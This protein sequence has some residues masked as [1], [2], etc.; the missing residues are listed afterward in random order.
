MS[1]IPSL[2]ELMV[3]LD[4]A[5]AT[6]PSI[7]ETGELAAG[8]PRLL[9]DLQDRFQVEHQLA[10]YGTLAPGK[11]NHHVVQPLGGTWRDG[12]VEGDLLDLG[13]GAALGFRALLPRLGGESVPVKLLTTARLETAWEELDLFEGPDYERLL[14]PVF[15]EARSLQAEGMPIAVAYLYA[16]RCDR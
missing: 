16:T 15:A 12:F 9:Q 14:V 10:T 8:R 2:A 6:R 7:R 4:A 1:T 5:N 13:W 3:L 11:S